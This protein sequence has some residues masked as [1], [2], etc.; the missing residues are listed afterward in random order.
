[1]PLLLQGIARLSWKQT[2]AALHLLVPPLT[3]LLIA[4]ILVWVI[5]GIFDVFGGPDAPLV[6]SSAMLGAIL[7]AVI[8]AWAIAG[9]SMLTARILLR[10]PLYIVWKLALYTPLAFRKGAPGWVRTERMPG[11]INDIP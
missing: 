3:V 6:F 11:N 1:V 8:A 10:L 9:R 4:N 5:F 2:W 7:I